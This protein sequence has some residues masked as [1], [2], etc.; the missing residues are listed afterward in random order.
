MKSPLT[1]IGAHTDVYMSGNR[2]VP[3]SELPYITHPR[4]CAI[5]S[6]TQNM[7]LN[8]SSHFPT[9]KVLPTSIS[10]IYGVKVVMAWH[11]RSEMLRTK[12]IDPAAI[13]WP[14]LFQVDKRMSQISRGRVKI[15]TG[16]PSITFPNDGHKRGK[17][18]FARATS[19]YD[20]FG[21]SV[22]HHQ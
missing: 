10:S 2:I 13:G 11:I 8:L 3:G 9:P 12:K 4:F 16:V 20:R 21:R 18:P 7:L 5:E 19:A 6:K 1:G 22:A 15:E 14:Y 17:R